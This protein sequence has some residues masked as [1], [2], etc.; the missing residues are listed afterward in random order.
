MYGCVLN[1]KLQAVHVRA[2][3]KE[4]R[5]RMC[6]SKYVQS[7]MRGVP[8]QVAADLREGKEVLFTGTG[9]QV[10]GLIAALDALRIDR[11]KLYTIDIVCHGCAS[12]AVF[13]DY[14]DYLGKK[15]G[16][17]TAFEFRD[18]SL[19][20][21][22]GHVE[23]A[24]INGKKIPGTT[25]REIFHTDLCLRPSCYRCSCAAVE[26][27]SDLTIA[28]AWGIKTALPEFND[29]RGVS[30]FLVQNEKG[31]QLLQWIRESCEVQALPLE[32]MMQ[33]NL[34]RPSKPKG[35]RAAFW[36]V[37]QEKGIDG[38]VKR[39]G[40]VPF[41]RRLESAVKYRLRQLTQAKRYF[42]P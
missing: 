25:Y 1:D 40:N 41:K 39:Y 35:D 6:K 19:R 30:M 33:S 27:R 32:K 5:D 29:N 15:K 23:S 28:D 14:L 42:L 31:E 22:D 4:E 20:G 10:E 26:R 2:V 21:W 16:K 13:A 37:Y 36:Q 3:T 8:E 18:K 12:P 17:V 11:S 7:D 24:V 9:C 38:I 34:Q